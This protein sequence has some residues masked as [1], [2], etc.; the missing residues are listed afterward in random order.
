MGS[1]QPK[2]GIGLGRKKLLAL[3]PV[4]AV[5]LQAAIVGASVVAAITAL[6]VISAVV[7]TDSSVV[8]ELAFDAG[9]I[10]LTVSPGSSLVT[11]TTPVMTPGDNYTAPFTVGNAGNVVLRYSMLS[12][13]NEDVLASELVLSIRS[14]VAECDDEGWDKTGTELYQG[15]LGA[16]RTAAVLGSPAQGPDDGDRTI[17]GGS[18]EV[19]CFNVTLPLAASN[20]AQ[21][22]VSTATFTF[23][24]EQ[25]VNLDWRD[26]P[27]INPAD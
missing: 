25:A 5:P 11:M 7:L 8:D 1:K 6:A 17:Q 18:N 21:G 3:L 9:G 26:G 19:L 10:D 14:D 12:T 4:G 2:A 13:T 24:A 22:I 27:G 15:A 16:T 20:D 23:F